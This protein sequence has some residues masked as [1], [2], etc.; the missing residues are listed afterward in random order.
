M[1]RAV[2]A[3]YQR[4]PDRDAVWRFRAA[5]LLEPRISGIR[6]QKESYPLTDTLMALFNSLM[7]LEISLLSK[8][9]PC[10]EF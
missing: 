6:I 3:S 5:H 9:I 10:Y 8:I 7:F 1:T 2:L 4:Q